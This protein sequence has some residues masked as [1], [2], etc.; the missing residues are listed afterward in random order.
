MLINVM[1][2]QLY[3]CSRLG[4]RLSDHSMILLGDGPLDVSSRLSLHG[5]THSLN[6]LFYMIL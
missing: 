5:T 3:T 4:P 2:N 6:T 1:L